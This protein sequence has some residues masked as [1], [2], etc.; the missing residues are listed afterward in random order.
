MKTLFLLTA[1][2]IFCFKIG[3]AQP[4][5]VDTS[6]G[7]NGIVR[8]DAGLNQNYSVKTRKVFSQSDGSMFIVFE[9]YDF[10]EIGKKRPDGSPDSSY[11]HFG[12]S[13]AIRMSDTYTAR[14]SDGKIIIAGTGTLS[15]DYDGN[16]YRN[17]N[18]IVARYN[19]DGSLDHTFDGDGKLS[20]DFNNNIDAV[21][22][23]AIQSDGK[24]VVAGYSSYPE[25]DEDEDHADSNA[26]ARYNSDGSPDKTFNN[27][28]TLITQTGADNIQCAIQ[29]D[30]KIVLATL[31]GSG[32]NL[33]RLN[34]DGSSDSTFSSANHLTR[35]DGSYFAAKSLALQSDGKI[36]LGGLWLNTAAKAD[37]ALARFNKNGSLDSTFDKDGIQTTDFRTYDDIINAIAIQ[38]DG[39]IV[40]VGYASNGSNNAFAIARYNINGLLDST[41]DTD[42]KKMNFIGSYD[43]YAVSLDIQNDGKIVAAGYNSQSEYI[44][45]IAIAKYN[46]DGTLDKTLNGTGAII[47]H[48]LLKNTALIKTAVQKNGKIA[49]AGYYWSGTKQ[50]YFVASCNADGSKDKTF[51]HDGIQT[52][53]FTLADIKIQPDGKIVTAGTVYNGSNGSVEIVRYNTNGSLDNSFS[54]DGKVTTDFGYYGTARSMAIQ[55]DGKIVIAGSS[56]RNFALA[57]YNTDGSLDKTFSGDGKLTTIFTNSSGGDAQSV[58]I[59]ADG[60]IVAA[61][62]VSFEEAD[63]SFAIARYN[64]NGTL[65]NTFGENGMLAKSVDDFG[66]NGQDTYVGAGT[67]KTQ[68][69]GKIMVALS[70]VFDNRL[71]S[72]P[73]I[74]AARF[75]ADGSF[76]NTFS[77]DGRL[78]IPFEESSWHSSIAL[79]ANGKI[80]VQGN[81][82]DEEEIGD[83]N[84]NELQLGYAIARLNTDGGTDSTFGTNGI[85][86][87][88]YDESVL[89]QDIAISGNKLYAAG[90]TDGS[91]SSGFLTRLLLTAPFVKITSPDNNAAFPA[92]ATITVKAIASDEDGSV[93][94]VKF[95]NGPAYLKTVFSSPYTYTIPNLPVGTYTLTAKA[96]DNT[97]IQSF[98]QPV[99]ISVLEAS[100]NKAPVVNITSPAPDAV[101]TAPA[102][103]TIHASAT[104]PDGTISMVKFYRGATLLS[105]DSTSPYTSTVSNLASGN[106]AFTAK[107]IDNKGLASSSSSVSV[108][109]SVTQNKAPVVKITSPASNIV[110]TAP[111]T[112]NITAAAAD[113][114]G[115]INEVRIYNGSTLIAAFSRTSSGTYVLPLT[116]I[117]PGNYSFVAKAT[118]D[119]GLTS[120]SATTV[121]QVKAAN[122]APTV[123]ISSPA[124]NTTFTS[125]ATIT[126]KA[127]AADGD[128]T[129]RSVKFYNGTTYLKTVFSSPYTYTL[130]NLRAG[131][132][133]LTAKATDDLGAQTLSA[134]VTVKVTNASLVGNKPYLIKTDKTAL[135]D[136]LS[137]KLSPNPATNILNIYTSGLQQ[138]IPATFSIISL[139]GIVLKT[140]QISNSTIQLDVSTLASGIYTIKVINADRVVHKKFVKL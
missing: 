39:K 106:Y 124:N 110:Y 69:D 78:V 94:S 96:T 97:G 62:S 104:D 27:S 51:S 86:Q 53:D 71:Y 74:L 75:N 87:P 65:D 109:V 23:I 2:L 36:V 90:Y 58:D 93:S 138:N 73:R 112:I 120:S 121:V 81:L 84:Y 26:I 10:V 33:A 70:L 18:F 35:S 5:S 48:T 32:L 135:N 29:P 16:G 38:N 125:P 37:F 108:A 103:I 55:K 95:Y 57:R 118:D 59:E 61:G 99:I 115:I 25:N 19:T 140:M 67:V 129:V 85:L 79:Q 14:Q 28:G 83:K 4:G 45:N 42:G 49:A 114:D 54:G 3:L 77:K 117:A 20:T 66:Y 119:Q 92:P 6:F 132:Y 139:S 63:N 102:T 131:T 22:S 126:V 46:A 31:Y 41:F 9:L 7:K 44:T 127:A 128:G 107:A 60:K 136:A 116:D 47:S 52:T 30:G 8:T 64:S 21:S 122:E 100:A 56:D 89:I 68:N 72:I 82:I 123:S 133:S 11:G 1:I 12:F 111:A 113:P 137:L 24:I 76:D 34:S 101:Y 80:L 15:T 130:S 134:K 40:A 43:V 13:A 98:S 88:Q 105:V 91:V 50:I 17:T